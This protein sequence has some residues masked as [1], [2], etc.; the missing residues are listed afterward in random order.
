[1]AGSVAAGRRSAWMRNVLKLGLH[2]IAS[3]GPVY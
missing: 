1:M 3:G 2:Q